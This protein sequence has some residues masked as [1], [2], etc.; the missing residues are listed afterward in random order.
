MRW[1]FGIQ[2]G[3]RMM[4]RGQRQ[5]IALA[6]TLAAPRRFVLLD[7]P[8]SAQDKNNAKMIF[9]NLRRMVD[10][11]GSDR[12]II[13]V[14]HD[15]SHAPLFDNIFVVDRGSIIQVSHDPPMW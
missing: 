7:E 8:T 2:M 3:G 10:A 4:S 11:V 13:A 14:T 1:E 5:R 15:L 6:R 9:E 12:Q